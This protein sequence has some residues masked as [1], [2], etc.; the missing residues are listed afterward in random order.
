MRSRRRSRNIAIALAL[1]AFA[2]IMY[3][4]TIVK[5]GEQGHRNG[6]PRSGG[7]TTQPHALT[8]DITAFA[9]GDAP[10]G[11]LQALG[12]ADSAHL[13]LESPGLGAER[14]GRLRLGHGDSPL[15]GKALRRAALQAAGGALGAGAL[16]L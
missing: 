5:L 13:V 4:V 6:T 15:V 11:G 1:L 14:M 3:F 12:L 9:G 10:A 2:F 7:E 16:A 8:S